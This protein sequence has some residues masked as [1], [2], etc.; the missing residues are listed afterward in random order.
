MRVVQRC[1]GS[2]PHGAFIDISV[3][4]QHHL[5]EIPHVQFRRC[6]V[7]KRTLNPFACRAVKP[8]YIFFYLGVNCRARAASELIRTRRDRAQLLFTHI[9]TNAPKQFHDFVL[10]RVLTPEQVF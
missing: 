8:A 9:V 10:V 6:F 3:A 7:F 2:P 4:L 1:G 5:V